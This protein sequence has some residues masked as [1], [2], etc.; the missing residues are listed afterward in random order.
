MSHEHDHAGHD[1]DHHDHDHAPDPELLR[2]VA[3][4]VLDGVSADLDDAGTDPVELAFGRL[5][6][7]EAIEI[8]LDEENEEL[9]LDVSPLMGGVLV[10]VGELV[11]LLAEQEGTSVEEVLQTVRGRLDA[12]LAGPQD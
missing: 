6:E 7:L 11:E 10:V 4:V 9:E 8:H 1:H 5:V 3:H 2:Q 12:R